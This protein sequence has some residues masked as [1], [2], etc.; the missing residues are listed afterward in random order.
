M[1]WTSPAKDQWV[2]ALQGELQGSRLLLLH[3]TLVKLPPPPSPRTRKVAITT[4]NN[5]TASSSRPLS[6]L[7]PN[8]TR[9]PTSVTMAADIGQ[10]AQLLNATLDPAQHRKGNR[11]TASRRPLPRCRKLINKPL[12]S[13]ERPQAGGGQAPVLA[14]LAQHCQLRYPAFQH[15]AFCCVGLQKL[16][17]NQLRGASCDCEPPLHPVHRRTEA[18]HVSQDEEGN[19]KIP[20]DEVTIIKERLIGLMISCP[21]SVQAQLGDAIS[22]IADSDFWRRWDTL[23]Q[24]RHM[25]CALSQDAYSGFRNSSVDFLAPIPKSTPASSKSP[26]PS[27]RDG[28]HSFAPTSFTWRLTTSLRLLASHLYS[29]LS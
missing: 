17:P 18:E 5:T 21:P 22:V 12:C 7:P 26:T 24:V 8:S 16:H 3:S 9:P 2:A 4:A 25:F 29:F 28:D 1:E 13:R 6:Y 15:Q 23:T 11:H 19:Y 27:S 10:I 14:Q 20:Q